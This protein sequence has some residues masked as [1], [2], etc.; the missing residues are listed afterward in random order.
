[1][2][3][4]TDVECLAFPVEV[5]PV[6]NVVHLCNELLLKALRSVQAVVALRD[7]TFEV[8][9]RL[10]NLVDVHFLKLKL[11]LKLSQ[12]KEWRYFLTAVICVNH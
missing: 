4:S 7:E 8:V 5:L 6:L 10:L 2:L 9:I 11:C 12:K 3:S 1:M